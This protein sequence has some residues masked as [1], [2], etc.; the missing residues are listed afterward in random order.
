[1]NIMTAL[2]HLQCA[3]RLA[4]RKRSTGW[5]HAPGIPRLTPPLLARG[6]KGES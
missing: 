5:A 1:M 2:P 3:F 6:K 4:R